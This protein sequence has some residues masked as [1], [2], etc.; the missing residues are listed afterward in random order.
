MSGKI[1]YA[2]KDSYTP[3][4]AMEAIRIMENDCKYFCSIMNNAGYISRMKAV[5]NR[6]VKQVKER[7]EK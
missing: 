7:T 2:S 1:G 4:E 5:T 3:P 6:K